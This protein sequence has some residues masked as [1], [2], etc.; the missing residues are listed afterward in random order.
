MDLGFWNSISQW[1]GSHQI[2]QDVWPERSRSPPFSTS[3]LLEWQVCACLF[4]VDSRV[5]AQ[6]PLLVRQMLYWLS[7]M[8]HLELPNIYFYMYSNT[9]QN[10]FRAVWIVYPCAS[11]TMTYTLITSDIQLDTNVRQFVIW[12]AKRQNTKV[13][14][15]CVCEREMKTDIETESFNLLLND[16]LSA[17]QTQME[18]EKANVLRY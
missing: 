1:P 13:V 8:S 5:W 7:Y 9:S 12:V 16:P 11:G 3:T 14:C 10:F 2:G 4:H 6:L 17:T 15:M 18:G